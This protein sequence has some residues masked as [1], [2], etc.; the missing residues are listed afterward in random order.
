MRVGVIVKVFKVEVKGQG[1]I[2]IYIY[3]YMFIHQIMVA[4]KYKIQKY[5]IIKSESKNIQYALS[6]IFITFYCL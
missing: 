5:T 3:I 2:Y 6:A 4:S 1:Y